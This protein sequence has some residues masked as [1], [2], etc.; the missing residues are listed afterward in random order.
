MAQSPDRGVSEHRKPGQVTEGW[1]AGAL[2]AVLGVWKLGLG[3]L[4]CGSYR[5]GRLWLWV[6]RERCAEPGVSQPA[7]SVRTL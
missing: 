1:P 7:N 2:P 5:G 4:G 3:W 6:S